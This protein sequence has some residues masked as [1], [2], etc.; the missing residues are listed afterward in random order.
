MA[1]PTTAAADKR[2]GKRPA[3]PEEHPTAAAA[4]EGET[5]GQQAAGGAE[6]SGSGYDGGDLVLVTDCGTEVLL[7]RSAAR[8]S[9]AILHMMEDDCAGGRVPVAG[10]DAGVLRLVVA[11]CERHAPHYDAVASAARLRD[12][13]PP[14]PIEFP[15]ANPAIRPVTDPGPDPHG[16][17]AWDKKFIANLPD[18]SALFAVILVSNQPHPTGAFYALLP[19]SPNGE[20]SLI[21]KRN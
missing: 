16:L 21:K 4:T 2:E 10:V 5:A 13:F 11:Y 6:G 8:M 3:P 14:F 12:P 18:N 15:I 20:R 7:S 17:E 19:S 1:P 9:T